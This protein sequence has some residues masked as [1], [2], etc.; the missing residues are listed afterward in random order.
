MHSVYLLFMYQA[1]QTNYLV[2][3]SFEKKNF[4]GI[5]LLGYRNNHKNEKYNRRTKIN[6]TWLSYI[7][8]ANQPLWKIL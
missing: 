6:L 2:R 5:N 4:S 7:K 3:Q 1:Q 8:N